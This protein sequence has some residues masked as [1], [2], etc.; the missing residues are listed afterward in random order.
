MLMLPTSMYDAVLYRSVRKAAYTHT[1]THT[2][3]HKHTHTN[4]HTQT[5]KHVYINIT[6]EKHTGYT[7]V[8][9]FN[10]LLY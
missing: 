8:C 9:L 1:H 10:K 7:I 2:H 6:S 5:K 4:T 3:A